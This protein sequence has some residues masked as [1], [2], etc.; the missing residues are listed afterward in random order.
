MC[1]RKKCNKNR[2]VGALSQNSERMKKFV[3]A[4]TQ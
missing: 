1:I 2:N 3:H 4:D